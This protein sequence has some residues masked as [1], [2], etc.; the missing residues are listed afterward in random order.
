MFFKIEICFF[1]KLKST[2]KYSLQC[3]DIT[4]YIEIQLN[5]IGFIMVCDLLLVFLFFFLHGKPLQCHFM[6]LI[7]P[8]SSIEMLSKVLNNLMCFTQLQLNHKLSQSVSQS[9]NGWPQQL[10]QMENIKDIEYVELTKKTVS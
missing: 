7:D 6:H 3:T 5:S 9:V 1:H 10:F 4:L 8:I 2:L